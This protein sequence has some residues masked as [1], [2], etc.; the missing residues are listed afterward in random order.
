MW[1]IF[2]IHDVVFVFLSV[3]HTVGQIDIEQYVQ[4][5][6]FLGLVPGTTYQLTFSNILVLGLLMGFTLI[7]ML[8][9]K[10][11]KRITKN[12][13]PLK[14]FPPGFTKFDLISL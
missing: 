8:L 7:L 12:I 6:I 3:K 9:H 13:D 1:Q 10:I 5:F 4:Q 2:S 11:S 14:D